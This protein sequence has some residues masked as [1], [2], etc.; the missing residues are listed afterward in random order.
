MKKSAGILSVVVVLGVAYAATTWYVGKR[1]QAT[2]EQAVEQANQRLVTV[3]GP[4]LGGRGLKVAISEYK[5][6]VFSSDV[7]Y[8]LQLKDSN[9]KPVEYLLSDHLQHGPFPVSAVKSGNLSPLLVLSH[10]QLIPSAVTQ[11][12]FDSLKGESPVVATTQ[13]GFSG[14]GHSQWQFKPLDITEDGDTLQFSGGSVAMTFSNDFK[15]SSA[16]GQFDSF[17]Y[18]M[19]ESGEKLQVKGIKL[20]SAST[21]ADETNVNVKSSASVDNL[22]VSSADTETLQIEAI[23][24]TLDS[25]QKGKL[26]Q[27]ALRYDFGRLLVGQADLGSISVGAKGSDFDVDALTA[28]AV[29]YDQIN[30]AHGG[31]SDADIQLTGK[32]AASLRE[33][34]AAV[35]AT[36]PKVSIDPVVWKNDKGESTLAVTVNLSGTGLAADTGAQFDLLL[37]KIIKLLSLDI[38]VS[39]PMFVKAFGQVQ[40]GAQASPQTLAIG[41]MIFDQY[42]SRLASAGLAKVDGEKA[43]T[44]IKYENDSVDVNGQK[45]SVA[46]LVQR[47]LSVVM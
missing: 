17:A 26:V 12:W 46:E 38:S 1:A 22:V 47:G 34:M 30:A 8:T 5:R 4:D 36:N 25:E 9:G 31:A 3:L 24:V 7:V 21:T 15:N 40:E 27:G 16:A 44:S 33:K 20:D 42:S 37:P 6:H 2:I 35:L 43:V 23:A 13:V 41:T 32:E 10:A 29:E 19:A 39:K 18:A 45:M 14:A 11:K 28:L